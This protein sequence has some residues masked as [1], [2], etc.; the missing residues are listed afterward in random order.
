M[1]PCICRDDYDFIACGGNTSIPLKQIFLNIALSLDEN[2]KHFGRF[3]FANTAVAELEENVFY[4]LTFTSIVIENAQ[5]L[6]KINANAFISNR[7]SVEYFYL[8]IEPG[9]ENTVLVFLNLIH[10][11]LIVY[12]KISLF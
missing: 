5:S 6:R 3:E 10:Y 2:E 12:L 1:S 8:F 9:L 11:I 7:E 4:D